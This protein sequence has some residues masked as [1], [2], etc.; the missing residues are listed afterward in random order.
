M[1]LALENFDGGGSY[2]TSEN[3]VPLD[4]SGE[5][6]GIKFA[7]GAEL[8]RAVYQNAAAPSCLV[9]RMSAYALG[10]TPARGGTVVALGRMEDGALSDAGR[11]EA[12][13]VGC[14]GY[15]GGARPRNV[16]TVPENRCA[17]EGGAGR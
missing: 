3:G 4:T 9:D 17:A 14:E 11:R 10:R 13:R 15:F 16:G 7:N 1:G 2:R 12:G 8:G 5:L 6:D